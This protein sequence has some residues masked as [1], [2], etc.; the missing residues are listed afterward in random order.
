MKDSV[1]SIDQLMLWKLNLFIGTAASIKF[2]PACITSSKCYT[3]T[4]LVTIQQSD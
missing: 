1:D 2:Y 3:A 4:V